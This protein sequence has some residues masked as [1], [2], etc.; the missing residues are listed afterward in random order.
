MQPQVFLGKVQEKYFLHHS[1][2]HNFPNFYFSAGIVVIEKI[3]FSI[4]GNT[5]WATAEV[6]QS[7]CTFPGWRSC[8]RMVWSGQIRPPHTWVFSY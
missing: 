4:S 6:K 1:E 2:S 8:C 3:N 5:D 7:G